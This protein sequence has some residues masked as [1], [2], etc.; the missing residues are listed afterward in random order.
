[1]WR[2]LRGVGGGLNPA[3]YLI[4]ES[5]TGHRFFAACVTA[6]STRWVV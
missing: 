6:S 1:M 4:S 3:F 2:G 5:F